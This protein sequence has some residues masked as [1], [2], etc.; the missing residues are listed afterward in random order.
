MTWE[1]TSIQTDAVELMTTFQL[2]PSHCKQLLL[3]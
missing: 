2:R 1:K 3:W